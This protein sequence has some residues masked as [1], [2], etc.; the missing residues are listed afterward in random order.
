MD[1]I[2]C[3]LTKLESE[4]RWWRRVGIAAVVAAGAGWCVAARGPGVAVAAPA[5]DNHLNADSVTCKSL[6]VG[7]G[8]GMPS[9]VIT[10][11]NGMGT[12]AVSAPDDI[13]TALLTASKDRALLRLGGV[14]GTALR[15]S[16][17]ADGPEL[18][19]HGRDGK[20]NHVER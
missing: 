4:V 12:I 18:A 8:K 15:A 10:A 17:A 9:I 5:A 11:E 20:L 1:L 16:A 13:S 19:F 7:G 6:T 2:E 3:R 14:N